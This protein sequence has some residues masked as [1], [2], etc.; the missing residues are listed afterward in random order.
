MIR[1]DNLALFAVTFCTIAATLLLR[2]VPT[3]ACGGFF[4]STFPMNQ[5]SERILFVADGGT[6]TTHVQIQYSGSAPDFAWILPVP[7]EPKLSVSHNEIFRQLQSA[8]QPFFFLE[9]PEDGGDCGFFPRVTMAEDAASGE[10]QRDVEVVSEGRV[11]PYQTAVITSDDSEAIITWLTDNGYQLGELGAELLAPYVDEGLLFLALRLAPDQAAGDLQPIALTYPGDQPM[12]PIRL[13]AVATAPDLGVLVWVLGEERA[14]PANYLHVQINEALIDWFNGG[15]NYPAVV[16]QAA[17]EAGGQSFATDYAGSPRIMED[18]LFQE[19]RFDLEALRGIGDPARFLETLL[20]QGFPRDA[21]MQ[22]LLRRH[23]PIP[24]AVLEEGILQVVFGGD[25]QEYDRIVEDGQLET[26]A[27][28]AFYNNIGAFEEWTGDL[29]F[30]PDALADELE[31]I[32]V[33]PLR[34]GQEL[35]ARHRYLTRLF[36]TLSADEMTVD[37][38]FS[39]NPDLPEV[40]NFRTAKARFECPLGDPEDPNFEEIVL[41]ITLADGREI[42]SRPFGNPEPIDPTIRRAAAV[43]EQME[44]SGPPRVIQRL[45]AI[46]EEEAG[47]DVTPTAFSLFPNRPNPFN[48]QTIIPFYIPLESGSTAMTIYNLVGQPIRSSLLASGTVGY[49]EISWDGLDDAGRNVST[50]VYMVGLET[51]ASRLTRK[52]L[53]IK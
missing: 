45:T 34:E 31:A 13:T 39:F 46:E 12:I 17:D 15:F 11:G 44:S 53:L 25:R 38:V 20:R 10:E 43:I 5:V 6:M 27:E 48:S 14:I 9:W 51:A 29:V 21:Q 1:R 47:S 2:P 33:T 32:V 23:I 28:T 3:S 37:P 36:T 22:S 52:L 42:R 18:R 7:S 8:T 24:P 41:V 16:A 4:C 30:D 19:G 35:F 26:I 50:G 40:N 49:G